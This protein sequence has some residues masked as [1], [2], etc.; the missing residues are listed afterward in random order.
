M[1]K[2]EIIWWTT[3]HVKISATGKTCVFS[4]VTSTSRGDRESLLSIPAS[5]PLE[6]KKKKEKKKNCT[7]RK[8]VAHTLRDSRTITFSGEIHSE[9][10]HICYFKCN[11]GKEIT[12][13]GVFFY[14]HGVNDTSG[15]RLLNM[16]FERVKNLQLN[17]SNYRGQSF[18]NR[19]NIK[20]KQASVPSRILKINSKA[21]YMPWAN[22]LLNLV[23]VDSAKSTS[24][25]A[26]KYFFLR[27]IFSF[28]KCCSILTASVQLVYQ[29]SIRHLGETELN[30][31]TSKLLVRCFEGPGTTGKVLDR[32]E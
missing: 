4:S 15:K 14:F 28:T 25:K 20:G 26:F 31:T 3:T 32:E 6:Q 5:S 22:Y 13:S 10:K 24:S 29:I 9:H 11:T 19:T 7:P 17:L 23:A 21:L 16:F 12:V 1:A 2:Q 18:N 30:Q 27:R 8:F